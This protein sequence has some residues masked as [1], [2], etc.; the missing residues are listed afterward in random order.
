MKT[1]FCVMALFL[2]LGTTRVG[3]AGR[4]IDAT[5][6][7]KALADNLVGVDARRRIK[8]WLP[9]GYQRSTERYP[10]VYWF[11]NLH[12]SAEKLFSENR[13]AEFLE[14]AIARRQ[15]GKVIV[16]AGDFTTPN[17]INMFG[18]DRVAGRWIDHIAGELVPF[19]DANYRTLAMPASRGLTGDFF[20]GFAAI[21]VAMLHPGKF[22]AVYAMH[23]V[24]TGTGLQ[25][26]MWRPNW[27]VVH[28]ARTWHDL[29]KDTYASIFVA[30]AQAYL[31]N[32]D[33]PPFFCD[34]MV[35]PDPAAGGELRPHTGN[36]IAITSR[37]LLDTL[38]KEHAEG[39]KQLRA[40]K[41]DW[42]RYDPTEGHVYSNQ[43]LTRKLEEYGIPHFAEEYSGDAWNRMWTPQGRVEADVLPFF[44]AYLEGAAP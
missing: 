6:D 4:I 43:A 7:S 3:A 42:G 21:K 32:P 26:G 1:W 29:Q 34:F 22:G 31:P 13:L 23:P 18:N 2:A 16:V 12:W 28:E 20:G 17:G 37:F 14:R 41:L 24:G 8:I 35:E 33:R 30:M 27:K 44:G 36:I 19:V 40:L 5:I 25:P 38:L 10:V 11:H 9:D 15:L 39:L